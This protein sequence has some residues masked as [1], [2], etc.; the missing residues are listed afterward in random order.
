MTSFHQHTK[1]VLKL[2]ADDVTEVNWTWVPVD[3]DDVDDE[4]EKEGAQPESGSQGW[5]VQLTIVVSIDTKRCVQQLYVYS[6]RCNRRDSRKF[7][8]T[9]LFTISS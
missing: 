4:C 3:P 8:T 1:N 7:K 2:K 6:F 9:C 5:V